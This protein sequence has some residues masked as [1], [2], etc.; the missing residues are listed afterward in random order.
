MTARMSRPEAVTLC[1]L[2]KAACPQQAFDEYTPD[3]WF[4]MLN[5]LRFEDCKT[6]LFDVAKAQ[7][8][9]SP[10]EIR[11]AVRR[12]RYD[13][14]SK[15]G[16]IEPYSIHADDPQA[17]QAAIDDIRRRVADGELTREEYDRD[18]AERGITGNHK[19]PELGSVFRHLDD[20][21]EGEAS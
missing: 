17:E 7:P 2:A 4:E 18:L 14:L 5:D 8:F 12:V 9:V 13:R 15:F 1:R 19:M 16:Y 3:A 6:A 21:I 11:A 10:S 20:V